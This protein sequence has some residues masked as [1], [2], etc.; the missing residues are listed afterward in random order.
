M[1]DLKK[2]L[3][4]DLSKS[5]K[6]SPSYGNRIANIE[7]VGALDRQGLEYRKKERQ[8]LIHSTRLGEKIFLQYP[9][10]E[11]AKYNKNGKLRI[12]TAIRPWDFRPRIYLPDNKEH[13]EDRSFFDI[14]ATIF[15]VADG[16]TKDNKKDVLGV[17]AISLYRMAFMQDH[18]ETESSKSL[19]RDV[20]PLLNKHLSVAKNKE[21]TFPGFFKYTPKVEVL[22]YL[23]RECPSFGEI[24]LEAFLHYNDILAWN[25]D[26]KYYYR[27]Y[28]VTNTEK[29]ISGTG[30]VNT[31]LTHT[32]ILGFLL[33]AVELSKILS[34]F[35]TQRGVSPASKD[36]ISAICKGYIHK[37]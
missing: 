12:A 19:Y 5:G 34:D 8:I 3:A 15:K 11:S 16:L 13:L 26:C 14:W 6:T 23:D 29:W 36:E 7:W 30:R 10:K 31:L 25:E 9:G 28:H 24:S 22:D 21:K 20:S 2:L 18:V 4:T 27:N 37:T 1:K 35:S 32:R 33:G 17:L